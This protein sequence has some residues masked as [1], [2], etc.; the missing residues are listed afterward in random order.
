MRSVV[1]DLS[2]LLCSYLVGRAFVVVVVVVGI[3][4]VVARLEEGLS[5]LSGLVALLR[6]YVVGIAF[7]FVVVVFGI[8][9]LVVP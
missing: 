8:A 3:A 9:V 4:L 5:W 1:V 2:V 6:A 7:V